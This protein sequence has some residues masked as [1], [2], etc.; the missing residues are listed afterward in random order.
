MRKV[1]LAFAVLCASSVHGFTEDFNPKAFV[2]SVPGMVR[3]NL[4][5]FRQGVGQMW[6]NGK[7]AKAVRLS[8]RKDG[9]ALTYAELQL[10]RRAGEDT[11]K[12]V[13]AGALWLF[14]PELFPVLLYFYPRA[15]PSTFETDKGREKRLGTLARMRTTSALE[16]LATLE[17]QAAGE[18][19]KA[20]MASTQ[21]ETAEQLL[22][23]RSVGRALAYVQSSA[24]EPSPDEKSFAELERAKT[25]RKGKGAG[26]I[27][28]NGIPQP[29][30][31]VSVLTPCRH[32][33][34]S[35]CWAVDLQKL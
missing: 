14:A 33:C 35:G 25:K 24:V 26:K 18:G 7:S 19:R 27:A 22:R 6:E 32:G 3:S 29:A 23:A 17:N 30:L 20:L 16:F 21:C 4:R 10:L 1:A 8:T 28:L 2:A 15:L 12:L 5:I 9:H 13:Q 11:R 31:K 34:L